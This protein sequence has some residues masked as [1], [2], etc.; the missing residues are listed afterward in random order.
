[1]NSSKKVGYKYVYNHLLQFDLLSLEYKN[2]PTTT[3]IG[4]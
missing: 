4:M 2:Y 1:M 3:V